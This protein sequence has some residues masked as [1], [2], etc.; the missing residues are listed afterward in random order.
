M[1]RRQLIV[2]VTVAFALNTP[3]VAYAQGGG[4]C[5]WGPAHRHDGYRRRHYGF[6]RQ[7]DLVR[8]SP[9]SGEGL[10]GARVHSDGIRV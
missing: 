4:A 10:A 5:G 6:G 8:H 3:R 1:R 7:R 2:L 9:P